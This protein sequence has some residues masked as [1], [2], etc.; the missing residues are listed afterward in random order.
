[1][2][3]HNVLHPANAVEL[4]NIGEEVGAEVL[5]G[6][7]RYPSNSGGWQLGDLDLSEHLAKYRDRD[8]IVIIASTG[9]VDAVDKTEYT[10]GI[11]GFAC[12]ERVARVPEVSDAGGGDSSG[13]VYSARSTRSSSSSGTMKTNSAAYHDSHGPLG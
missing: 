5:R 7:S 2:R 4:A 8:V 1:M 12:A 9:K 10:C 13:S 3:E 6:V 11:C